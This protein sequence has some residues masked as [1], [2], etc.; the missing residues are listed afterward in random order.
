MI[1][2]WI[3]SITTACASPRLR[4][5]WLTLWYVAVISMILVVST[6]VRHAPAGFIYQ[7]F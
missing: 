3:R 2:P 5:F 7:D 6:F 1:A 4:I